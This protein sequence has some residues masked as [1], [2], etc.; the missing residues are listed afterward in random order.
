[1]NAHATILSIVGPVLRAT[2]PHR[3]VQSALRHIVGTGGRVMAR[4]RQTANLVRL[5]LL[6]AQPTDVSQD[7]TL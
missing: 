7:F 6:V 2:L 4:C 3:N 5:H 1:M